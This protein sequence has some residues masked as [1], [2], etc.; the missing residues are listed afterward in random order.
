MTNKEAKRIRALPQGAF[1]EE[2]ANDLKEL[3]QET[4]SSAKTTQ[5]HYG[6]YMSILS[7]LSHGDKRTG[8]IVALALIRAGAN[9]QGVKDALR[10]SF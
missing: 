5:N 9:Q 1:V 3:V 2:L 10:L 4:E 7:Q 8:N 6:K